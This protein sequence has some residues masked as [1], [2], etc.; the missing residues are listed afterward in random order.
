[1]SS[2]KIAKILN[3]SVS[4]VY[5]IIKK[6]GVNRS[7]QES[8]YLRK[9][10]WWNPEILYRM[11]I[12]E[13]KSIAEIANFFDAQKNTI[14]KAIHRYGI[15]LRPKSEKEK[16]IIATRVKKYFTNHDAKKKASEAAK[17]VWKLRD[18]KPHPNHIKSM[19]SDSYRK[20]M[21]EMM[22]K[23]SKTNF[24][25]K[26]SPLITE[27]LLKKWK[28]PD[29]RNKIAF[30]TEE[31]VNLSKSIHDNKYDYSMTKYINGT[32]D[33]EIICPDHGKFLQIA[34]LH[35]AGHGCPKC[36]NFISSGHLEVLDYIKG[37]TSNVVVNDRDV[38][39]PQELD[40][41]I[42]D[43]NL[44]IEYHGVYWHSFNRSESREE[45]RYHFDK[46]D[47]CN[48]KGIRLIQIFENEWLGKRS[49]IESKISSLFGKSNKIFAR[50]CLIVNLSSNEFNVFCNENHLQG[51]LCSS[52]RY[53]LMDDAGLA[54]VI[55]FNKIGDGVYNCSRFCNRKFYTVTGGAGRLLSKFIREVSP[56]SIISFADRRYSNGGL[57]FKLG[58]RLL[59]ITNPN[60]FYVK[61]G[62][63][64]SRMKFQKHKLVKLLDSFDEKLSEADNMFNNGYRRIWDAGNLKFELNG[65]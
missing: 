11:Y 14:R 5:R 15:K 47:N 56:K 16:A 32:S 4:N 60:Y 44:A 18:N 37:L 39:H 42:P 2:I 46:V 38:I 52:F 64:F 35:L 17:T 41:M 20:T 57:Y 31:F 36:P 51:I 63:L 6:M 59:Y 7:V 58:F 26:I 48:H 40:I 34:R 62:R 22:L 13:E 29:F 8:N 50:K 19:R 30:T 25:D 1:M 3:M 23:R 53:G 33:V 24:Y 55:G 28:D 45:R 10:P 43:K 54:C 49:I 65:R 21:R 9:D 12:T 27:G 61:N